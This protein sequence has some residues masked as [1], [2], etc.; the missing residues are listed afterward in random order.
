MCVDFL[1]SH[2]L[3]VC[4]E[5]TPR[6]IRQITNRPID[7]KTNAVATKVARKLNEAATAAP[8]NGATER[9]PALIELSSP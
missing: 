5:L 3:L 9:A 8:S 7:K 2:I 4:W 1:Y 6:G